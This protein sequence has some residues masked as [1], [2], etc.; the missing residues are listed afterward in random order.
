MT[1]F[2][3]FYMS[4]AT[5][6]SVFTFTN[7]WMS[8]FNVQMYFVTKNFSGNQLIVI[9]RRSRI[10]LIIQLKYRAERVSVLF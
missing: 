4:H 1:D 6:I 10:Y 3:G 8:L 5:F 2:I 7:Y 9:N